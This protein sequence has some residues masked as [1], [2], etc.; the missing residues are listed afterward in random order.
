MG[1]EQ[2]RSDVT[3]ACRQFARQPCFF[4]VI[5]LTL[6]VGIAASTSIFAVV[7]GVLLRPLPYPDSTRLVRLD[8]NS[9]RGEYHYLREQATTMDIGAYYPAP[10]EVT[11]DVGDEP[12]SVPG[13][14]VTADLFDVLGVRPALG[15]GFTREEMLTDGPGIVGGTYWRT[16]GVVI[17]SDAA[18]RSYF[19]ADPN[20]IGRTLVIE[21]VAHTIVG[22]MPPNFNFPAATV[23]FWFPHNLDPGGYWGG[24]VATMIGRLRNGYGTAE[25]QAEVRTLSAGFREFLPWAQFL[26]ADNVYGADFE[27]RS[28]SDDIVGQARPVLLLLL[29]AIGAVLLVVC[30]N[31]ANLLL[32]RGAARQRELATRAALGAGRRRLVRQLLV[33]NVTLAIVAGA[34]GAFASFATLQLV[35]TLLPAD[36]PRLPEIRIDLR[37]L[38]FAL[39]A[40]LATGVVFGLL[41]A[42]RATRAGAA[43]VARD[44]GAAAI[45]AGESR[46]TRGLAAVELA[47]AVV[48]V[49]VATLLIRS[50]LN[51]AAVDPG[52]RAEQLVAAR[53]APPGFVDQGPEARRQFIA[54]LLERLDGAAG[55]ES[56]AVAS[57]IPFDVGLFGAGVQIEGGSNAFTPTY[58]GVSDGYMRVMGTAVLEGR[59]FTA[60][61]RSGSQRVVLVSRAFARANFPDGSPID[62]RIRFQDGRQPPDGDT[63]LPWFTIVG[64]VDDVRFDNL[65]AEPEPA[66]Y[67]PHE[68]FWDWISLRVVV[69][70]AEGPARVAALLRTI[71]ASLDDGAAVSDVRAYAARA[72]DTIARP[73]FTAQLLGAFAIVA[74]FLAAIGVYGVL[75]YGL[76]RRVPE[77]GVRVAFGASR[78]AV[79]GLLF[80]QGL[81]V[82]LVGVA[83]G[84][85]L[86]MGASQLLSSLLFGVDPF[87]VGT[88]AIVAIGIVG[89]GALA[90][91]WPALTAARVNPMQAL[92]D[93]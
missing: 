73:R 7:D 61:D 38:A 3:F 9:F 27:V 11:V 49:V 41:P 68:Q 78:R 88:L 28:L 12:M 58:L 92:R 29:A 50:L 70:T 32:A 69:R 83:V 53:V 19:A 5:V 35:L 64:V 84:I 8:T 77:I 90:S 63:P 22:I 67:L 66:L 86:A 56:A 30:V 46:L 36:L 34:I 71:V 89:V 37:V 10:M 20:A 45:D 82:T 1:L 79:F 54:E 72:G 13:A 31:V 43:L 42:L 17:L 55:V 87:G 93:Q 81:R 60:A 75:S 26:A 80:K 4:T 39:G 47:F 6:I 18:W 62:K 44:T 51:L 33:E 52:F 25:A 15:R 65:R 40:S 76:S 48:L 24:N 85:P 74:V 21:G 23:A 57:A 91:C 2:I 14:G 59:S 16:Y